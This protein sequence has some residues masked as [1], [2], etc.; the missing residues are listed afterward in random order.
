MIF[1]HTAH[2]AEKGLIDFYPAHR[3]TTLFII[4]CTIRT[5]EA[6]IDAGC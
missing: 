6:Q 4:R 5:K 2:V 1:F 3:P